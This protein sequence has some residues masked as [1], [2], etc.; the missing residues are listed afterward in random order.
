MAAPVGAPKSRLNV[1][2]W[3]GRS[4]SL[5]EAVNETSVP[6][7]IVRFVIA[8]KI[9]GL[10]DSRTVTVNVWVALSEGEPVSTTRMAIGKAL[11]PCVSEGVQLNT[12]LLELIVAPA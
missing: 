2:V 12:P 8:V 10:F 9:G 7:A 11:P 6:S 3:V 4:G 5:A 1:R